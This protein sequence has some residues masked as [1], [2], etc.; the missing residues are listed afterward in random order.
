MLIGLFGN[1]FDWFQQETVNQWSLKCS[2]CFKQTSL[3][4]Q[5]YEHVK[6][7]R[8]YTCSEQPHLK[9][10]QNACHNREKQDVMTKHNFGQSIP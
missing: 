8:V 9:V 1:I 6:G 5:L 2:V 4:I 7:K 10:G 3:H